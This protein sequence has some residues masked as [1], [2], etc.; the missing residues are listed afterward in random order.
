M[1]LLQKVKW[2]NGTRKSVRDSATVKIPRKV[3]KTHTKWANN[4]FPIS[5]SITSVAQKRG[6]TTSSIANNIQANKLVATHINVTVA[7]FVV[8]SRLI[9]PMRAIH[10]GTCQPRDCLCCC[11][12]LKHVTVFSCL[13]STCGESGYWRHITSFFLFYS[14]YI[15]R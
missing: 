9:S 3:E 6:D 1:W 12:C 13:L 8:C 2:P 14:N 15:S 4:K 10:D 11:D 7:V 5:P